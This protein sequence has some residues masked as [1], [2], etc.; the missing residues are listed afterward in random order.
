[1]LKTE[2]LSMIDRSCGINIKVCFALDK[3][4]QS[5]RMQNSSTSIVGDDYNGSVP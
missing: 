4:E 3:L 1:M 2:K 5:R